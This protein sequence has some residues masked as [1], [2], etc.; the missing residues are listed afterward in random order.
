MPVILEP[1]S[2]P[3]WLG[4]TPSDVATLLRPS[5]AGFKTWQV[6]T[7]VNAV[8]NDSPDLLTPASLEPVTNQPPG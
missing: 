4:E 1:E 8:R 7:A 3:T 5:D 2:W 6:S